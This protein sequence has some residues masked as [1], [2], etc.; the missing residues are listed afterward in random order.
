MTVSSA[1]L[2]SA[3]NLPKILAA[4]QNAQAPKQFSTRFLASPGF[5]S[6]NDRLIIG[7]LKSLAFL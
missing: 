6:P 5:P 1:Y 3:Q 4:I 7:V 2:T